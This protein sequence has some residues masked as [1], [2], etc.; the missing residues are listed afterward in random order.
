ML[1]G[2]RARVRANA[3]TTF[4]VYTGMLTEF[5]QGS[6]ASRKLSEE[7]MQLALSH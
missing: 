4:I 5:A 1:D 3:S 6:Q 7:R 2:M